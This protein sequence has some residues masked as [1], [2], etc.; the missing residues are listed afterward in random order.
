MARMKCDAAQSPAYDQ[1]KGTKNAP[2][3]LAWMN[4]K[5]RI[6]RVLGSTLYLTKGARDRNPGGAES[7]KQTA[8]HAHERG[9]R[10]ASGEQQRRDAKLERH[11]AEAREVGGPG[12]NPV[13][14]Q[15]EHA[16]HQAAD[17]RERRRF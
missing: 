1:W 2:R 8:G 11:F 13:Y 10:D 16:P 3:A 7:R 15:R 14:G 17:E 5:I 4:Q 9:E 12:R 6:C